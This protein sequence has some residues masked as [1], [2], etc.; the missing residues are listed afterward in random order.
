MCIR[1]SPKTT[2]EFEKHPKKGEEYFR[3]QVL[4]ALTRGT[5]KI[6][7]D[8]TDVDDIILQIKSSY[9]TKMDRG[10]NVKAKLMGLDFFY[11][12]SKLT[13][14]QRNEFITDMIFLAQKKATKKIDHFGPFGKIY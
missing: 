4:P 1:D 12:V 9:G 14:A 10:T 11:Q 6:T 3:T 8:I 2:K 13:Q 5:T 7:T